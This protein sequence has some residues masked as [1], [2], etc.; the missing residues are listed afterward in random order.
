M[1]VGS[2]PLGSKCSPDEGCAENG[3]ATTCNYP[4][5]SDPEHLNP[6]RTGICVLVPPAASDP[7][8]KAGEACGASCTGSGICATLCSEQSCS[9]DLPACYEADGLFCSEA[10]TCIPLGVAGDRCLGSF[11]C[12]VGTYCSLALERCEPLL[13]AGDT[14]QDGL[15]CET[16]YCSGTCSS[17]PRAYPEYCLGHIPPPPH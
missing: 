3:A 10:N 15:Q 6:D 7:H 16:A 11:E 13:H 8:G 1:F 12:G 14:C 9:T 17:P 4:A 5:S 2:V